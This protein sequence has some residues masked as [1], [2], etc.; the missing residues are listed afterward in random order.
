[1]VRSAGTRGIFFV[2]SSQLAD[3]SRTNSVEDGL[4]GT[5]F[6]ARHALELLDR[7][8]RDDWQRT[9]GSVWYD[10]IKDTVEPFL[11]DLHPLQ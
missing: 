9:S 6:L 2:L 5:V 11:E 8:G 4:R 10:W 1:M 7:I 3:L